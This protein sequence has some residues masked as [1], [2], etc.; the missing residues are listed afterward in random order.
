[1]VELLGIEKAEYGKTITLS[2][3]RKLGYIEKG[4]SVENIIIYFHGWPSSSLELLLSE[5]FTSYAGARIISIDRPGIGLS[6]F[7]NDRK[8][9]DIADDVV[10]LLDCLNIGNVSL[11]GY[12]GGAAYAHACAYRIPE[13]IQSVSIISG[14][15]PSDITQKY[16]SKSGRI[17][18]ALSR[19]IPSLLGIYLRSAYAKPLS[20]DDQNAAKIKMFNE[21]LKSFPTPDQD[22][23]QKPGLFDVFWLEMQ[24]AFKNGT[25]GATRDGILLTKNWGFKLSEISS[26]VNYCLWHGEADSNVS[27]DIGRDVANALPNCKSKFIPDEGHIS[28]F[29]K[30]FDEIV[31]TLFE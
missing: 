4:S 7:Q 20:S 14:V 12:S 28:L 23:L 31:D 10:E 15:G 3:G 25:K 5:D 30:H 1:M 27:I 18:Y 8:I 24:A 29:L 11:I 26:Q 13:R 6:S 21:F 16:V 2:D 17:M 9:T 22:I 19:I